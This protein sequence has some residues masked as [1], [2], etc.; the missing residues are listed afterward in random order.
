MYKD[1]YRTRSG[2]A[3]IDGFT[4]LEEY[5]IVM[6]DHAQYDQFEKKQIVEVAGALPYEFI[7]NQIAKPEFPKVSDILHVWS[8]KGKS[9][10]LEDITTLAEAGLR[11]MYKARAARGRKK[12]KV[13]HSEHS[14]HVSKNFIPRFSYSDNPARELRAWK[15]IYQALQDKGT[16]TVYVVFGAAVYEKEEPVSCE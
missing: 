16:D 15:P 7:L 9:E 6:T 13:D 4:D 1:L 5:E 3:L 8:N 2:K 12:T 14:F 10:V 11:I